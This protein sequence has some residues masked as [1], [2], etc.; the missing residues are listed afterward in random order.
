MGSFSKNLLSHALQCAL[1]LSSVATLT[2]AHALP[3]QPYAPA[4]PAISTSLVYPL[5]GPRESSSFGVRKHPIRKK[6]TH[7]HAGIDLAAPRG[8]AIRAIADGRVMYSDPHGGYG[9]FVVIEHAY[10]LTSHYGHC[11]ALKVR[12]GQKVKAG[13]IIATV[14]SS[15]ASTGPHLHFEIRRDGAPQDPESFLPGLDV[16]AR[17]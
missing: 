7:H 6:H 4:L 17:G 10:G 14:G 13:D 11:D 8:A 5:M 15:G 16:P 9:N 3:A 2:S 1:T 12:V